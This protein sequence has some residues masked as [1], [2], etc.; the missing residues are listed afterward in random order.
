M[1]AATQ[2][3]DTIS[4]LREC[5][6]GIKM[7]VATLNEIMDYVNDEKLKTVLYRCKEKHERLDEDTKKL[8]KKYDEGGKEPNIMAKGMSWMKTNVMLS[9][10][11]SDSAAADILTDGCGMGIKSLRKYLNE[12]E[13]ADEDV[14]DIAKRLI[15]I[16]EDALEDVKEFL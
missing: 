15:A 5:S 1:A 12:Y 14:R 7:G 4:L 16:E 8:L 11:P 9:L 10:K 13:E 2:V 3:S 6:S